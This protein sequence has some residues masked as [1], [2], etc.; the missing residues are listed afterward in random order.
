MEKESFFFFFSFKMGALLSLG[1]TNDS[2]F[3]ATTDQ[4]WFMQ[5]GHIDWL[6][7]GTLKLLIVRAR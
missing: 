6:L 1:W 2:Q 4:F 3:L 5:F 7:V